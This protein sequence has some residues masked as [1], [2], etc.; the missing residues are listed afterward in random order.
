MESLLL[1]MGSRQSAVQG[2]LDH[3]DCAT[4]PEDATLGDSVQK[5]DKTVVS[6]VEPFSLASDTSTSRDVPSPKL[7]HDETTPISEDEPIVD[8]VKDAVSGENEQDKEMIVPNSGEL[9]GWQLENA[10]HPIKTNF[11]QGGKASS[12]FFAHCTAANK[13]TFRSLH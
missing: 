5:S 3:V 10:I 1:V 12:A 2:L 6:L 8:L 4:F 9:N 13:E 11:P 7:R